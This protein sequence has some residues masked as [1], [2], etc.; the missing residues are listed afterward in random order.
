MYYFNVTDIFCDLKGRDKSD[1][2]AKPFAK[3]PSPVTLSLICELTRIAT[4]D[5]STTEKFRKN[6]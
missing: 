3:L 4:C 6:L 1:D 2:I 5:T